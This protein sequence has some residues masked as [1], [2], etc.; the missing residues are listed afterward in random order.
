MGA[1]SQKINTQPQI[2]CRGCFYSA[3]KEVYVITFDL[4]TLPGWE[5]LAPGKHTLQIVARAGNYIDSDKS[6]P[7][8]FTREAPPDYLCFT[9]E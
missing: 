1:P 5:T 8:E 7:T 2:N 6:N 3:P 4:K 9:A